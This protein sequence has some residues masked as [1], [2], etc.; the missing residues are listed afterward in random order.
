MESRHNRLIMKNILF[1]LFLSLSLSAQTIDFVKT[2]TDYKITSTD[3]ITVEGLKRREAIDYIDSLI[4]VQK[5]I[6]GY[7]YRDSIV[8]VSEDST[9]IIQIEEM[10]DRDM[11][12]KDDIDRYNAAI[13]RLQARKLAIIDEQKAQREAIKQAQDYIRE[14]RA[15][16][17]EIRDN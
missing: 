1:F 2:G 4:E 9:E 7:T 14:L 8:Q 6:I 5:S 15:K 3:V 13:E 17:Q 10:I 12:W 16:K 11:Q